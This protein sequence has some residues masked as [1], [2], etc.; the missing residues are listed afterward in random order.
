[1]S[2]IVFS[3]KSGSGRVLL[4]NEESRD[5]CLDASFEYARNFLI[6]KFLPRELVAKFL[7]NA[8]LNI[9]IPYR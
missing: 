5:V 8:I 3:D 1:V 2:Y 9:I 4:I 7:R 6:Y